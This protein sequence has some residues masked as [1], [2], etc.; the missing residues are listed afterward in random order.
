MIWVAARYEEAEVGKL[1][2]AVVGIQ[3][4][5]V[6]EHVGVEMVDVDDWYAQSERHSLGERRADEQRAQEPRAAGE[7]DGR[8]V[9]GP[10]R[11]ALERGVDYRDDVLLMGP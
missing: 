8:Q 7:G 2:H 6:G 4:D 10:E 11:S 5:E 3:T 9:G 1:R